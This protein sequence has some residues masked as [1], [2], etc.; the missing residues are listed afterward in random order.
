M[1]ITD[2]KID[3]SKI[4]NG[5]CAYVD[6]M[7][8]NENRSDVVIKKILAIGAK[9][10]KS[11]GKQTTHLIFKEGSAA[12]YNKAKSLGV[13]IVSVNWVEACEKEKKIVGIHINDLTKAMKCRKIIFLNN[14]RLYQRFL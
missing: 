5:V 1:I 2:E 12:N 11:I 9:S 4:L 8:R 13:H 10:A 14:I 7:A 3:K 6:V